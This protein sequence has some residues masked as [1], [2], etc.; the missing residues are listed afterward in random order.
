MKKVLMCGNEACGEG[1]VLAGCRFY[2]GYPITPQNE[3]TEYMARRLPEVG[4]VFI[5]S[6]SEIAAINMVFGASLT[7]A[8]AM[9]S[10]SSPGI[11]LK[12][13]G[14]SYMAG[15]EIPAVIVNM[16][17]GGPGLGN[18]APA[19]SDYFQATRGGGHG[20]YRSVV[21]GPSTVQEMMEF[22]ILA[23]ELADKYRVPAMILGDG[24]LGQMM[25]PVLVSG[26]RSPVSGPSKAAKPWVLTGCKGREPRVIKSLLLGDGELEAFNNKL[27]KKYELIRQKETRFEATCAEDADIVLVGYGSVARILKSAVMKLRKNGVRAGLLRP[28]TLWPFPSE[29]VSGLSRQAKRF[30]VV[31][32]SCGQMVEDVKL[33]VC[34]S[35]HGEAAG[36]AK[37]DFYGR[38][39]GGIPSE[40]EIIKRVT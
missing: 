11:S 38:P 4:G 18:I 10:S 8:R 21:L 25:E 16:M 22:T 32:M 31:E 24:L 27:Q 30:L 3:L 12:Q 5:Q 20:D 40:E 26:L 28:I 1:A 17:R 2:A 14:I 35:P 36:K 9:T 6:E 34:G 37:I 33:A 13:E 19:Q 23:F 15:C 39:G 29:A 7:G